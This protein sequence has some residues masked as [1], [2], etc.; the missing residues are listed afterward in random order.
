MTFPHCNSTCNL[1][2]SFW[3]IAEP[4]L[5][6]LLPT[7]KPCSFCHKL[8]LSSSHLCFWGLQHI[9]QSASSLGREVSPYSSRRH[10]TSF[11][12]E[13]RQSKWPTFRWLGVGFISCLSLF[14]IAS[15][16]QQGYSPSI[17]HKENDSIRITPTYAT[18]SDRSTSVRFYR[19]TMGLTTSPQVIFGHISPYSGANCVVLFLGGH[20]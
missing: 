10:D 18:P 14:R 3:K 16:A 9:L 20:E 2:M 8:L 13:D 4:Q 15:S 12:T 19:H 6:V 17:S 11:H 1:T 7:E 5:H